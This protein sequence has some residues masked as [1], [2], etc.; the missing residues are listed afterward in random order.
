MWFLGG[1]FGNKEKVRD[2]FFS[3]FV[4][5]AACRRDAAARR[6]ME[7]RDSA[8]NGEGEGLAKQHVCYQRVL[9]IGHFDNS[10]SSL[11]FSFYL[12]FLLLSSAF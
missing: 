5:L 7:R 2:L 8:E 1:C 4:R 3:V 12:S 6:W 9:L 10:I 11:L